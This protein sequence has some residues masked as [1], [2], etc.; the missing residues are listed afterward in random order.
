MGEL[1]IRSWELKGERK[2]LHC[3]HVFRIFNQTLAPPPHK[4]VEELPECGN[5]STKLNSSRLKE[6]LDLNFKS[7]QISAHSC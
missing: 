1:T 7:R 2:T 5:P 6:C 4:F 3:R